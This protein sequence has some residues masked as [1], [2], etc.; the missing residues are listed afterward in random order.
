MPDGHG[1][2]AR[3]AL[4]L[5]ERVSKR[6]RV[7]RGRYLPGPPLSTVLRARGDK[8]GRVRLGLDGSAHL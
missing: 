2:G 8:R 5:H 7:R 1:F 6:L 4:N 3:E